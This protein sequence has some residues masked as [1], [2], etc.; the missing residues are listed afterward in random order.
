[1]PLPDTIEL[2]IPEPLPCKKITLHIVVAKESTTE[3]IPVH[4][5]CKD[6]RTWYIT[7]RCACVKAKVKYSVHAI[8]V[9]SHMG[10]AITERLYIDV[11]QDLK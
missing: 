9:K 1:M 2:G 11:K 10:S 5:K 8:V 3:K 4:C 7:R 6:E